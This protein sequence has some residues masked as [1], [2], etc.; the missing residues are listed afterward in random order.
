MTCNVNRRTAGGPKPIRRAYQKHIGNRIGRALL[1]LGI[2]P[3]AYALLETTGRRTGKRRRTP[4]GNGLEPGTGTFWLISE[5]GA[6][7]GYVHNIRADPRVRVKI[8]RRWHTGTA[9]PLPTDDARARQSRMPRF[10]AAAVR[11]FGAPNRLLTIRIDLDARG[12]SR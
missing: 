5:Y 10:N 7:A 6:G 1:T 9:H 11:F 12:L 8:G 4:I 2:A 3:R